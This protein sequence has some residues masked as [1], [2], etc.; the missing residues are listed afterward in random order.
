LFDI[1][2]AQSIPSIGEPWPP[3]DVSPSTGLNMSVC[4]LTLPALV[5]IVSVEAPGGDGVAVAPLVGALDGA[6]VEGADDEGGSC[7][8]PPPPLPPPPQ[9]A[10]IAAAANAGAQ[11][12][13]VEMLMLLAS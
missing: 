4:P 13:I 11:R 9:A 3:L 2:G 7:G 6:D 5:T 1:V 12:T 10:R 8:D